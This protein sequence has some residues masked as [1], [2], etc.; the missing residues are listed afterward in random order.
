VV[1]VH[2]PTA[3]EIQTKTKPAVSQEAAE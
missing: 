2:M 1:L 3:E